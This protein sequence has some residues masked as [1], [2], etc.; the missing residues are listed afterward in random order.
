MPEHRRSYRRRQAGS[1]TGV[2]PHLSRRRRAGPSAIRPFQ[3]QSPR[4]GLRPFRA[5]CHRR[6]FLA[7]PR[8]PV[9]SAGLRATPAIVPPRPVSA[10]EPPPRRTPPARE[11]AA[12]GE[13]AGE[14]TARA[15]P[16]VRRQKR[17]ECIRAPGAE[18]RSATAAAVGS[19]AADI[20]R[21]V[22]LPRR[23]PSGV[24]SARNPRT[25]ASSDAAPWLTGSQALGI[26]HRDAGPPAVALC[27]P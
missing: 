9:T 27:P 15:D 1:A 14:K 19:G 17:S 25:R 5:R 21:R 7:R 20:R 10:P 13:M 22:L 8:S 24:R 26:R 12:A 3:V 11:G 4:P 23:R 16:T 18:R 6:Q 2:E